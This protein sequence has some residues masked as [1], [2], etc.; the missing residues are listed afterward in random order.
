MP[1]RQRSPVGGSGSPQNGPHFM[2]KGLRLPP[3]LGNEAPKKRRIFMSLLG[4][5]LHDSGWL[6]VSFAF[7]CTTC[8]GQFSYLPAPSNQPWENRTASPPFRRRGE[9][10]GTSL[11]P[12][13]READLASAI[14]GV[15]LCWC[16]R[17]L[18]TF[19]K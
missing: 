3:V 12:T 14:G 9:V 7:V 6:L 1:P 13:P 18:K 17:L 4:R 15:G 2:A 11:L 10:R 19:P 5:Y 8:D 16:L